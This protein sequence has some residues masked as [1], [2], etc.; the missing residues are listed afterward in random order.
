MTPD[1]VLDRAADLLERDGWQRW[2]TGPLDVNVGGPRCAMGAIRATVRADL[3]YAGSGLDSEAMKALGVE[4]G[5][6][7]IGDWNDTVAKDKRQ[8][9]RTL[10]RTA[11]KL[12]GEKR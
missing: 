11:R 10:R 3:G 2:D 5:T 4:V 6:Y 7:W 12:R 9:V 1:Q 8:V